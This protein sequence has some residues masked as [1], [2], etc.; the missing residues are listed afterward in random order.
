MLLEILQNKEK[1]EKV[2]DKMSLLF[3]HSDDQTILERRKGS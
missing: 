2:Q 1:I 3:T